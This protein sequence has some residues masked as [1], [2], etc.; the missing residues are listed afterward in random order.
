MGTPLRLVQADT[1]DSLAAGGQAVPTVDAALFRRAFRQVPAAPAVIT[2]SHR[3]RPVGLTV[4][5]LRSLSAEPAL[6]TFSLTRTVSTWPALVDAQQVLV[7]VD[8][9]LGV[10]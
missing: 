5:S 9:A 4:T 8:V 7:P 3:N 6:L 10:G 2:T 1:A